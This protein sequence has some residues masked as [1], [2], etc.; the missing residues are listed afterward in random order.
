[1]CI[2]C[3]I[4][5][6]EVPSNKVLENEDFLAFHDIHPTAPVHVLVIPK[7]HIECFQDASSEIMAKMTP[8]IQ[9]VAAMLELDK[10]GYRLVTNNG[11]NGG[12]EISH[13]HF[14]ILGGGKLIWK[15]FEQDDP[16]KSI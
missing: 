6:N 3:K 4:A 15:H 1:M 14:H 9:E 2:F 7:V 5:N 12:Q 8:F 16:H 13:L 11:K 10:D